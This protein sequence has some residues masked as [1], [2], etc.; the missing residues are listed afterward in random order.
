[1]ATHSSILAWKMPWTEW[2]GRPQP[3]GPQSRTQLCMHTHQCSPAQFW[4]LSLQHIFTEVMLTSV[5]FKGLHA[6]GLTCLP[7]LTPSIPL[8]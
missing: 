4:G 2:A 8:R 3:M 5:T 6:V 1:M 7:D